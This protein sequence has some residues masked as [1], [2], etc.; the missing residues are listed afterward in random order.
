MKKHL[1]L[2][3][4]IA[5]AKKRGTAQLPQFE[6]RKICQEIFGRSKCE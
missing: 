1:I 6:V 2:E 5:D 3:R 4:Y